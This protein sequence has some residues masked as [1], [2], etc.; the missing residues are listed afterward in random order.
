M[1]SKNNSLYVGAPNFISR[2]VPAYTAGSSNIIVTI[3]AYF[4]KKISKN[5]C[6][7]LGNALPIDGK[8]VVQIGLL[9]FAVVS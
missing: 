7:I 8:T 2:C 9:V 3:F 6:E 4:L 5:T 1:T